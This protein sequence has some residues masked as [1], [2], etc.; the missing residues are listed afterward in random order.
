VHV[1][2]GMVMVLTGVELFVS[3]DSSFML[4]CAMISAGTA[5]C[6]LRKSRGGSALIV[7]LS[8]NRASS[9]TVGRIA[10]CVYNVMCGH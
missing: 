8:N 9:G 7:H 4:N 5:I 2:G 6:S 10:F 1:D 3:L